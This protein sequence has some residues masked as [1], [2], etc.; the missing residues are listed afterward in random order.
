ME[1]HNLG[2]TSELQN[3]CIEAQFNIF[4]ITKPLGKLQFPSCFITLLKEIKL[5]QIFFSS[6]EVN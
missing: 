4:R 1:C 5:I 6:E 2:W 3:L